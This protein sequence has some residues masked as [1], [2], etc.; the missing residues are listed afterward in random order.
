MAR[1]KTPQ[2]LDWLDLKIAKRHRK[3]HD[4]ANETLE[5]ELKRKQKERKVTAMYK[6]I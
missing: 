4:L 3:P 1:I 6:Y 5:A 2:V